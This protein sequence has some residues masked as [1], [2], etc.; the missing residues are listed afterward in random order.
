MRKNIWIRLTGG[1]CTRSCILCG[2]VGGGDKVVLA[3]F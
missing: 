1:S 3:M 2:M